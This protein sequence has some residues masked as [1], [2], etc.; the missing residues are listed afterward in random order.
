MIKTQKEDTPAK[1]N[2]NIYA[3]IRRD[4]LPEYCVLLNV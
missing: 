4:A 1:T 2:M 3:C